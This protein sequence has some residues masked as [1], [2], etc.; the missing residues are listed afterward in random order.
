M[1]KTLFIALLLSGIAANAQTTNGM[2]GINTNQ[3]KATLH[4]EAGASENKGLIIPRITPAEM[5]TMSSQPHFGQDQNAII[6]YLKQDL[7]VA[8]RTGKLV[9]VAEAGYYFYNHTAA[10]WQKFG[11][12]AEQ[13]L[14]MVGNYN[15]VTQDGGIGNNGTSLGNGS[16]NI[17]IGANYQW[18]TN[19]SS[20]TGNRNIAMGAENYSIRNGTMSGSNNT[21]IGSLLFT[22]SK[23]GSMQ[24][25]YNVAV[26]AD[27]YTTNKLNAKFT[28]K[29][30]VSL[31]GGSFKLSDG[32]FLGYNNIGVGV[33]VYQLRNDLSG[34]RNIALGLGS[35]YA[36][37]GSLS[38]SDNISI[39]NTLY[40]MQSGDMSASNNIAMGNS[41]YILNKGTGAVFSGV[42][43][44]SIGQN[45]FNLM[46]GDFIGV[47]NIGMG[48]SQYIL[49]SG[50]MAGA[51]N[52]AIG[53]ESYYVVN[54]DI[55]NTARNNIALGS[56]I[57]RLSSSSTSTF[58]GAN[59]IG[60]GNTL[61]D[62]PAGGNL[63]G[64][65]N[66]GMGDGVFRLSTGDF[67]GN[68]NIGIGTNVM[69]ASGGITGND[70]IGIGNNAM[71]SNTG[72]IGNYN[73]ALGHGAMRTN[74]AIRG[75]QNV[76]IGYY[77]L[78]GGAQIADMT[79]KY[80]VAIGT[81]ILQNN[82]AG[83]YNI[84]Q[85]YKA[86]NQNTTGVDNIALGKNALKVNITGS[87]NIS[88]GENTGAW[89]KGNGNVHIG[90]QSPG[91]ATAELDNVVAIGHSI[92]VT[93]S[94]GMD[95][96]I[97]LGNNN[98]G[99][100]ETKVGIGTY[101]PQ[102]KLDVNGSIKIGSDTTST[103][104]TSANEGAI[105]YMSTTKKFQGCDGTNWVNLN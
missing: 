38:G 32:D 105:R 92:H 18:F 42:Q 6:T 67:S 95:D 10:K 82:T 65:R 17:G 85:G 19:A 84:A 23:G 47:S 21:A 50:N 46:N 3:P 57:Y 27:I 39:G 75:G 58:S 79:G 89:I 14:R 71:S 28:G 22:M 78:G 91:A 8:D 7:P 54:G 45:I 97:L 60:I 72:I 20:L 59:N 29:Y 77:A 74:K 12:G 30:N 80:N 104:C 62:L 41:I 37:N 44:T 86:L 88:I 31:G 56:K 68:D 13:D 5:K 1:N 73:L 16:R 11:G 102:A 98:K 96:T 26:G 35:F 90:P 64:T 93:T 33:N 101:Q 49:G 36:L 48:R 103:T 94:T 25:E 24:G 53:Q 40:T 43:N 83:E 2:V 9:N 69:Q 34:Y 66:I 51:I 81:E 55:T 15:H 61:Y 52:I 87:K 100:T 63:T 76:A 99:G 4:I 70:N